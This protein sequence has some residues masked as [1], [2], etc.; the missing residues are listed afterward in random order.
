MALKET[1]DSMAAERTIEPESFANRKLIRPSLSRNDHNH[2]SSPTVERRDRP[3]RSAD[4]NDRNGGGRK[5]TPPEQTNA[6]NFYYLKQMQ[7]KTPMSIVLRDGEI[8]KGVIEWYDKD[9]LKVNREGAPNLLVFKS[10][11]KYM[12]KA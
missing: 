3:E 5:A 7:S 10:N 1:I 12:H 9:C 11:I 4:R 2:S 6:E 8:L